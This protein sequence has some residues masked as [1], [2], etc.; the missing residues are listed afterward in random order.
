MLTALTGAPARGARRAK[1]AGLWYTSYLPT[2]VDPDRLMSEQY[3]ESLRRSGWLPSS[4]AQDPLPPL[5]LRPP[6]SAF[7]EVEPWL[8]AHRDV[9][10]G[11]TLAV[12]AGASSA[13]KI[14]PPAAVAE[15]GCRAI[16]AG[17]VARVLL[18]EGPREQSLNDEIEGRLRSAGQPV[19][20]SPL[21][22]P[23][24]FVAALQR[25][26]PRAVLAGDTGPMHLAVAAQSAPVLA[27]FRRPNRHFE[28]R[29]PHRVL[30]SPSSDTLASL[31]PTEVVDALAILP[32]EI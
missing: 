7:A 25:I 15:A 24:P 18:L 30:Y 29:P 9:Q 10:D 2:R 11:R 4:A 16:E 31:S 6:A 5:S 20:R 22:K 32:T 17:L 3:A 23:V 12:F 19:V 8:E 13:D 26:G 28:P 21:W 14:W 1:T 27:L